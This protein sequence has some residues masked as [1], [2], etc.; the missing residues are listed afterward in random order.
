MKL[1]FTYLLLLLFN[2]TVW[3]QSDCPEAIT[4]CGNMT[5][6]NLDATGIGDIQELTTN[7]CSTPGLG[8]SEDNTIWLRLLIKDGGT[9]GFVLTPES[10][11]LFVDFDF[12][13]FGPNVE[14]GA[15]GVAE[16]CSTTNPLNAQLDYNTTGMN[17]TSEDYSEGP[18][19][20][21]DAYVEWITV[22]DDDVYYLLVNR[23]HGSSNFS[24]EWTGTA[25]FHVVP[26]F[27][28]PDNIPLDISLCDS[29]DGIFDNAAVFDLT[30]HEAMFI[31]EQTDVE[32]TYHNSLNDVTTGE[33][34]IENPQEFASSSS[35]QSIYMRMTNPVTGCFDI[36]ELDIIIPVLAGE[37]DDLLICDTNNNGIGEFD[38]SLNDNLVSGSNPDATV[39]Y[40]TSQEDAEEG[41]S[42]V[43]PLYENEAPYESEILWARVNVTG[44]DCF[45]LTTFTI[46]F[47]DIEAYPD[48]FACDESGVD[49]ITS[50]DLTIHE[51][52]IS[53][54]NPNVSFTYY[55]N[56]ADLADNNPIPTPENYAN[57]INPQTIYVIVSN[58]ATGC[59]ETQEF[60]IENTPL[61]AGEPEDLFLC[62]INL[63]G[64]QVFDLT[65][66]TSLINNG[67]T[68]TTVTFHLTMQDAVNDIAAINSMHENTEAYTPETIWARVERISSPAC[69]DIVPF[70]INIHNLPVFNNPQNILLDLS[71]CDD[72]NVDDQSNVF[73]LTVHEAMFTGSQQNIIFTYYAGIENMNDNNP[74]TNPDA[75]AN[76]SNPQT[77]YVQMLDT[78]TD[79]I[80]PPQSFDIQIIN[81]IVAGEPQDLWQCDLNLDGRQSF[82]L[83]LN[84]DYI[85]NGI[86]GVV[87]YYASEED[88][89]NE[90]NPLNDVHM[91]STP[92]TGQ[93]I[94]AR[95]E[96]TTGCLGFDITSFTISVEHL[97]ELDYTVTIND[98]SQYDNAIAVN[99]DNWEEYEYSL[100]GENYITTPYFDNLIPGL[101][102]LYIRSLDGCRSTEEDLVVLNYPKF[103]T[104]NGD[105]FNETWQVYFIYFLP[106]SKI[107]IFDRYGKLVS[108]FW[109]DDI[110][111]DGTYNGERLPS[112]DYWFLIELEDGRN[113]KGHFAMVR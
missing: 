59:T 67:N 54:G 98:F 70:T 88:A 71:Q 78:A 6:K 85:K 73:D 68:G 103:F 89:L 96:S 44:E 62:D 91:N 35:E 45:A 18:G 111:W 50:F 4:V 33:S 55:A 36:E 60:E 110:G 37:A 75:Y 52:V 1:K 58:P 46:G 104:P 14:C 41:T 34:P 12:W 28:N 84:D 64:F 99:L 49:G 47:T 81:P 107:S 74:I 113:V 92:Y 38:L 29:S 24:I 77:V 40:Y 83:S 90:V 94:W 9:L 76:V 56:S 30:I 13:I 69:F 79:C 80:S 86:E 51:N 109:G 21:G 10:D 63:N 112:T 32:I 101:Y 5:Y 7:A 102:T 66:N 53:G 108:S 65:E 11:N 42:S 93:T 16:R 2:V 100:D 48:V 57:T 39:T 95:L 61:T 8:D 20:D 23:P 19:A 15:L 97:P 26:A 3:A 87:T 27:L 105:G 22:E 106:K 31:G 72:D 43:G 25:T 82:I 17:D